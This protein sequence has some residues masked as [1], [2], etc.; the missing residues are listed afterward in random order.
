MDDKDKALAWLRNTLNALAQSGVSKVRKKNLSPHLE[1]GYLS[2]DSRQLVTVKLNWTEIEDEL[3]RLEK[4]GFL[5]VLKDPRIACDDDIC[6]KLN[7]FMSGTPFPTGWI[8][9]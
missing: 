1:F 8:R 3:R 6:A 9:D 7:S 4:S 5:I 2:S